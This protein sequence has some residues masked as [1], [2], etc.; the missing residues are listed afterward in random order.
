MRVYNYLFIF[1][2]IILFSCNSD[3]TETPVLN[4][5]TSESKVNDR[6]GVILYGKI[7]TNLDILDVGF[8]YS[9]DSLLSKNKT[10]VSAKK[11]LKRNRFNYFIS[12]GII[13]NKKYYYRAF[14]ETDNEK[15]LGKVKSFIS[16]GS[17]SP[18]IDSISKKNG[19][20]ADTLKIFGKYF[21]DIDHDTSVNFSGIYSE[22]ISNN[23]SIITCIVPDNINNVKNDV[24]V[25]IDNRI[26]SFSSFTLLKPEINSIKPTTGIIGDTIFINGNHFDIDSNRNKVYF[27]NIEASII[28][29]S[30][31]YLKVIVPE[32][33]QSPS[34]TIKVNAQLQDEIYGTNFTLA[35]PEIISISNLNAT[36][37]D[38]LTITGRNFDFEISR[39]KVFFGNIEANITYADKNTLK[40]LVPDNLENSSAEIKVIAQLQD[41]T[42]IEKFQL[43]PPTISFIPNNVNAN[44]DITI[45]GS[46][47]HPISSK[48][49]ISFE[50]I[51]VDIN[52]GDT[53][54]LITKVP[55]GPFPRR[56]AIVKLQ[57]LD[58]LI[59]YEIELS[60]KDKWVMV[61]NNLP[62]RF[63]GSI[64]N[65]VVIRNKAFI[66]ANSKK[67]SDKNFYLWKFDENNYGWEKLEVPF[68]L[69]FGGVAISNDDKI[70]VYTA[71]SN[72]AFWQYNPDNSKWTRLANFPGSRRD[73][74]TH[75]S[76]N[77]D[78]YLGMG[79][80]LEPSSVVPYKD[81]YKFSP[82]SGLWTSIAEFPYQNYFMRIQT[83]SFTINNIAYV[84]NGSSNTGMFDF[85]S[86]HPNS[87][88]WVRVSDFNDARGRT[89]AFELNGLGYVTGGDFT[90]TYKDCW[91]YNPTTNNWTK[92]D[93]IGY[94]ERKNHFSFSLNGKAYI[95]G[96]EVFNIGSVTAYD[97]Y[98]YIP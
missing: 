86:Y 70:F 48:N 77:G 54:S 58:I 80:D 84:G 74:A 52:S 62:F 96:G 12:T 60:I 65:A 79:A 25:I 98:E 23:D 8:E 93:D 66:I 37:R 92:I 19:H 11:S 16:N 64:N 18:K 38:E 46:F 85:W 56:K 36:F 40:V 26:G 28:E 24:K 2:F 73:F 68:D 90:G 10:S 30:R 44:Q 35:K 50:N 91:R 51:E 87:N 97:L 72:N 61:S 55:L 4:L 82:S 33:I 9:N 49:K 63:N 89:A 29:S 59:E 34:E 76:V 20:I 94:V 42:N 53:E 67:I 95:G 45:K 71:L 47:F 6:G 57:L 75:F 32:N 88:N 5:T 78:L 7:N 13:K 39:N 1:V 21:T 83:S 43:I 31:K 15:S 41:I 69:K 14:V 17:I 81:F 3:D 22:I 27:G